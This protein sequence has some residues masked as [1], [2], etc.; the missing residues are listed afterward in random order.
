MTH[1]LRGLLVASVWA[2]RVCGQVTHVA[3]SASHTDM[4]L[5]VSIALYV[6]FPEVARKGPSIQGELMKGLPT[7]GALGRH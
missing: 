2:V 6:R 5:C 1:Y 4:H 3:S 7:L